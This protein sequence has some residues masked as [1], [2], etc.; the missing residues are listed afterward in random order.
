MIKNFSYLRPS[1]LDEA[2]AQLTTPAAAAYA[3]G[4]DLLGCL[5]DGVYEVQ[6]V[7]SLTR[8]PELRGIS[9]VG[10]DL[11]IGALTTLAEVARHPAVKERYAALAQAA[12]SVGTPQLRNQGTLGGNLCQRPRCWYF[13]GDFLCARKGGDRCYAIG[14]ENQYHCILG[15]GACF[16]VHPSDTATALVALGARVTIAGPRRPRA[17]PL[18]SFFVLPDQNLTR[19]NVLE[20]GEVVTEVV[21][22][23]PPAGLVSAYRKVRSRGSWDFAL[24][25]AAVALSF[26]QGRV[27]TARVV[28]GGAAPV[29][30]RA[31]GAE[32]VLAGGRL[33]AQTI[34]RAAAA[35]VEG[36]VPLERNGYKVP[37]LRGAVQE[38]LE[39]LARS[40]A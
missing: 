28:L 2:L 34:T 40:A 38:V 3:G 23:A 39:G 16:M 31:Q 18:E 17:V 27:S 13:R 25:A 5:R 32:K 1:T 20:A 4:T 7:V 24:A 19:E 29:P 22:P 14:G 37:M 11:R 6:T 35:A 36:A 30:W 10:G 15:G 8:V 33:N 9:T 21:I 26:S 12:A